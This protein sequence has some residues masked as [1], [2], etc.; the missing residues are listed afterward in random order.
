MNSFLST[1][2]ELTWL[3]ISRHYTN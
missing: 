2:K 3:S 1:K